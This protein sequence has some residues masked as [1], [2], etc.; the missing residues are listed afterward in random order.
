MFAIFRPCR[1]L[2]RSQTEQPGPWQLARRAPSFCATDS[3]RCARERIGKLVAQRSRSL[4]VYPAQAMA[5]PERNIKTSRMTWETPRD[6]S[7]DFT[8]Q[9][10]RLYRGTMVT[11]CN[12]MLDECVETYIYGPGTTI[13]CC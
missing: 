3:T 5:R 9:P 10:S 11:S 6:G 12:P 4:N 1:L 8:F 7:S 2:Y 13:L